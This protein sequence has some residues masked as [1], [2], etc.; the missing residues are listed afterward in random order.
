MPD[1]PHRHL[2]PTVRT[3]ERIAP[4]TLRIALA[5]GQP[6]D[7]LDGPVH[8]A[9]DLFQRGA[10]YRLDLGKGLGGVHPILAD[11]FEAF[12]QDVL[13]HAANKRLDRNRFVLEPVG[14]VRAVMIRHPLPII[15]IKAPDRDGR[16]HHILGPVTRHTLRLRRESPLL[17]V[18]HQPVRVRPATGI[19]SLLHGVGLQRLASGGSQMPLPRTAQE[20]IGQVL[21]MLPA[22]RLDIIAPTGG[23]PMQ[24]GMVLPMT[25]VGVKHRHRAPLKHCPLDRAI[26][27]VQTPGPAPHEGTQ[28]DGGVMVEGRAKHCWH[29]QNHRAIDAPLV[30][31]FADLPNPVIRIDLGAA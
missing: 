3:P 15:P 23:Q 20:R 11:T 27:S 5:V 12:G 13:D 10:D 1:P 4:R 25:P 26:E 28:P 8:Q 24:V 18:G 19:H 7:D 29:G 21:E 30:Q 16:T 14:A 22:I 31:H 6:G 17:D 2:C 9:L